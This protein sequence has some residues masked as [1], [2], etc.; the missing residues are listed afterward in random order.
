MVDKL[1]LVTISF[2]HFG[3]YLTFVFLVDYSTLRSYLSDFRKYLKS[4]ECYQSWPSIPFKLD[5]RKASSLILC[6]LLS[7]LSNCHFISSSSDVTFRIRT[8]SNAT[9]NFIYSDKIAFDYLYT[10]GVYHYSTFYKNGDFSK[11]AMFSSSLRL[12]ERLFKSRDWK[13]YNIIPKE[14]L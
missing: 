4:G 6:Y 1:K 8:L 11:N 10:T 9:T 3:R 2:Y 13:E 12:S 14:K 7:I 5:F